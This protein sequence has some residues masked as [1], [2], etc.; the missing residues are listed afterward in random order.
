MTPRA[1]TIVWGFAIIIVSALVLTATLTDLRLPSFFER[2]SM[3]VVL[4]GAFGALLVVGAV[5]GG[6]ISLARRRSGADAFGSTAGAGAYSGAYA[7]PYQGAATGAGSFPSPPSAPAASAASASS[8]AQPTVPYGATPGGQPSGPFDRTQP[9]DGVA[10]MNAQ[11][12]AA[13]GSG[14]RPSSPPASAS[15][16]SEEGDPTGTPV[17]PVEPGDD[18]LAIDDLRT[19]APNDSNTDHQHDDAASGHEK[20]ASRPDDQA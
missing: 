10:W 18:Q 5:V 3:L 17:P 4:V 16:G 15:G 13:G 8:A 6:I 20:P 12:D 19:P 1:S 7:S 9:V 14:S 2:P 11:A